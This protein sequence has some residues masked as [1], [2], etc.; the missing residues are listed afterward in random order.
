[1]A[2]DVVAQL[3]FL[4][5]GLAPGGNSAISLDAELQASLVNTGD[6]GDKRLGFAELG[7]IGIAGGFAADAAVDLDVELAL[8]SAL[9]GGAAGKF[10]S[11]NANFVYR[12]VHR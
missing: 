3:G 7:S 2:G 5:L 8:N 11:V 12:L 9:V 10:P 6:S 4:Q 1:M